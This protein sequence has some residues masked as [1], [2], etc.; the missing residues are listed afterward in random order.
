MPEERTR[1]GVV[2][3]VPAV[4]EEEGW[5]PDGSNKRVNS[6]HMERAVS[7]REGD[8]QASWVRCIE[9]VHSNHKETHAAF[10]F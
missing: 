4:R 7:G 6:L 3:N 2:L 5:S 1:N 9:G 10:P 8:R